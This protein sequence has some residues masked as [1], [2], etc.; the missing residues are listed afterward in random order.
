MKEPIIDLREP[1]KGKPGLHALIVG[2]SDYPNLPDEDAPD[3]SKVLKMRRLSSSALAAYK[4]YKWLDSWKANL[5]VPL[6]TCRL[7]LSPSPLELKAEPELAGKA[8]PATLSNF[9][10]AVQQWREDAASSPK[11]MT[12]FY[13]AGH[14]VQR[15]RGDHVMLLEEFD[16]TENPM[17]QHAIDT[18]ALIAGMAVVD[19]QRNMARNQL[20]FVDACRITPAVFAKYE[21]LPTAP[22]WDIVKESVEDRIAATFYTTVPGREAYGIKG[23]QTVFSKA[24]IACLS[25]GAGEDRICVDDQGQPQWCVTTNSINSTL[26]HYLRKVNREVKTMYPQRFSTSGL[27]S[28]VVIH[29][30]DRPPEVDVLVH[31]V[32][33][34]AL[35]CTNV[36]VLDDG[37]APVWDLSTPDRPN[38]YISHLPAGIYRIGA[39]IHPP[40]PPYKNYTARSVDVRPPES[41]WIIKVD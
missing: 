38:P 22:L 6:T 29:R 2:V 11:N 36:E 37:G 8:D 33:S 28:H 17:L 24:L 9:R 23:E 30:F 7:L 15:V 31:V 18:T 13:F 39:K 14:G 4:I 12:L 5:E 21:D 26:D 19:D 34:L 32:P 41:K 16:D 25:G 40:N 27:S 20:Y 1:R 3:A 10:K 35:G